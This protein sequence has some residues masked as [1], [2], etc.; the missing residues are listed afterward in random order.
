MGRRFP[1]EAWRRAGPR[2]FRQRPEVLFHKPVADALDR[3]YTCGHLL[4]NIFIAQPLIG[5]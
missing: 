1:G 4:G 2:A 5:F 3:P